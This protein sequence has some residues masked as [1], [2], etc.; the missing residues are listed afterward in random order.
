MEESGFS[1]GVAFI[2]FT[3]L[4]GMRAALALGEAGLQVDGVQ[5]TVSPAHSNLAAA[6]IDQQ[7]AGNRQAVP[8]QSGASRPAVVERQQQPQQ[9]Q[10]SQQQPQQ[11][12]QPGDQ[13]GAVRAV[14]PQPL[15]PQPQQQQQHEAGAEPQRT[16]GQPPWGMQPAALG[17]RSSQAAADS[18]AVPMAAAVDQ[19]SSQP[20]SW[21]AAGGAGPRVMQPAPGY[22]PS[23]AHAVCEPSH[24]TLF[25]RPL[26]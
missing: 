21:R 25:V 3:S 26:G 24:D 4:E 14:Q 12:Q 6:L 7:P 15:C 8:W 2:T 10:Q 19:L 11:P 17:Q 9:P 1:A 18:M 23:A 5:P 22:G 13:P 16:V 20:G